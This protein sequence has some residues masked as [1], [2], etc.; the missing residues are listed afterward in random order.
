MLTQLKQYNI[1]LGDL[2]DSPSFSLKCFCGCIR[3]GS[4]HSKQH[5]SELVTGILDRRHTSELV[6]DKHFQNRQSNNI[7]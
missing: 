7:I 2:G 6:N 3:I 5:L 1:I 4:R